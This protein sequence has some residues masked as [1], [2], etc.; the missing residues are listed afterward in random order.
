M[1]NTRRKSST[2]TR[3]AAVVAVG[4]I[5]GGIDT[6]RDFHVAAAKDAL[7]RDL[8]TRRFPATQAGYQ[9]LTGWLA[10]FGPVA[11]AGVEGTGA[12]GAGVTTHLLR[13]GVR[14]VEVNR[15]NRQ[16]RRRIGKSDPKDAVAAAAAVLS[17]E[18]SAAPKLRTGPLESVRLL[19]HTLD[20]VTKARTATINL[21]RSLIVT[22]PAGLRESLQSLSTSAL[23]A[24]CAQY[25]APAVPVKHSRGATRAQALTQLTDTLLDSQHTLHVVLGELART[26]QRYNTHLTELGTCL[27]ALVTRIAPTTSALHGIG[28]GRTAQLLL[29]AGDNPD[30]VHSEA[31]FAA[32][33]GVAPID[34]SSGHTQDHHRL[35]R[36]GDRQ[37]NS[38]LYYAILT[39]LAT[40]Q[41]TRDYLTKRLNPNHSNKKHIIRCLK[42]YLVREIYPRLTT[43]LTNLAKLNPLHQIHPTTP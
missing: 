19:K 10:D 41:P 30:R 7:G 13:Q 31:A 25:A 17:G 6:H 20:H 42:R 28:P 9:A 38:V 40:H 4:E 16:K 39:R 18:A 27:K 21:L 36:A 1:A 11:V 35:S 33:T 2:A 32:L 23:L 26:I 34:C 22:A 3:P 8:G 24:H 12:Y 29:T 37:A 5:T 15:P 43:D 14:V